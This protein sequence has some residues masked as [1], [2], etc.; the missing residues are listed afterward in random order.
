[1]AFTTGILIGIGETR[2]ERVDSLLAIRAAHEKY[3]HIQEVIVQPFRAKPDIR[4]AQAPEPSNED[5]QRTIAVARLIL[6]GEMN[7]QSP[8]N[9]L[10]EDFP[11]LLEAGINDWGGIS[12][13]TQDFINPEAA[14]PQISSLAKQNR[15][16]PDSFCGSGLAIYPE[17]SSR[18]EFV[19]DHL[20]PHIRKLQG[21]DGYARGKVNHAE[22]NES[23]SGRK[24][25]VDRALAASDAE[26]VAAA[27]EKVLGGRDLD[28]EE[29]LTLA[30]VEGNDL[31]ALVKVADELR[32]RAVGDRIT[33]VVNRNLN[34]TNV[35]IVGCAF[36]GFSRGPHSP[37][38]YFHSTETL[39]AKSRRGGGARRNGSVHSRRTAERPRRLLLREL[40]RAI[41]A[42]LPELHLH[43]YS[44]MEITYGVE[45]T[46]HAAARISADAER[47][48]AWAAFRER[49]RKFSTTTCANRSAPIN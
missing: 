7:I 39:I 5:L 44:P 15:P 30:T 28:F 27:L 17:F 36:C 45:K 22:N 32:R 34:F 40:L 4:M 37:D 46:R 41:K 24:F 3:G 13:V 43:A 21:E 12:P 19:S 20:Q 23:R 35:C 33:Y 10:C 31:L 16:T 14:W 18:P 49:P 2:E 26:T 11:D 9:L 47:S 6:G 48:R 42:R 8:P 29:G 25:L 1:M 38:A